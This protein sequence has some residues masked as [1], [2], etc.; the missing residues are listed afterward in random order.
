MAKT[1]KIRK[2]IKRRPG[3]KSNLY[4]TAET[5]QAIVEY[6]EAECTEVKNKIYVDRIRPAFVDLVDN[7]VLVYGF[8]APYEDYDEMK[9]DAISFLYESLHKWDPDKG[10]L[11][12]SYYNVVAKNWLIIQSRKHTKRRKRHVS[13]DLIATGGQVEQISLSERHSLETHDVVKA[14]DEILIER[15]MRNEIQ[16]LLKEIEK[17]VTSEAEISC[18]RA[19]MTVFENI[20]ELD[21]LNKRAILIYVRDIS[22][23]SSKRLS[24]AMSSIR[25]HYKRLTSGENDKCDFLF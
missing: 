10:K 8:K 23:L 5:Q 15:N 13:L 3:K 18:I 19:I 4:F 21:F 12:F 11:A 16:A 22:G 7:L 14:P 24:V 9:S 20:D 1:K 17:L 2:K 25:K 6:Q